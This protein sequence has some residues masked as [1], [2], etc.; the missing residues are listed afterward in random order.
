MR[1]LVTPAVSGAGAMSRRLSD[2]RARLG[3][4]CCGCHQIKPY[5][6]FNANRSKAG[7]LHNRCR[8]C[9]RKR[10]ESKYKY[11]GLIPLS[12]VDI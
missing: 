7:G 12:T 2:T 8:L 10:G 9:E 11:R 3:K 5:T 6:D 4:M 1:K